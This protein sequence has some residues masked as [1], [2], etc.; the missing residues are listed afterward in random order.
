M[1]AA[2]LLKERNREMCGIQ[3][4]ISLLLYS[5]HV[6]KQVGNTVKVIKLYNIPV[7]YVY[8]TGVLTFEPCWCLCLLH[9]NT[10]PYQRSEQAA[11]SSVVTVGYQ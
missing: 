7:F 4:L 10:E 3:S 2:V 8:T 6:D 9:C 5:S 1:T 11:H